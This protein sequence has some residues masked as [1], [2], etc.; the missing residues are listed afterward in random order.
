MEQE[1]LPVVSNDHLPTFPSE[2]SKWGYFIEKEQARITIMKMYLQSAQM[3]KE[4][5]LDILS[6]TQDYADALLDYELKIA[7]S[8]KA[9]P[10]QQG[11]RTD[12]KP[13]SLAATKSETIA[14]MGLSK[15]QAR[16][17]EGLDADSVKQAKQEARAK[18]LIVTR[19][20]ALNLKKK[21]HYKENNKKIK[22]EGCFNLKATA[23]SCSIEPLYYTQLFANVGIGEF[24]LENLN[25]KV[26]VANELVQ[27]RVQWYKEHHP[28]AEVVCG[29]ITNETVFNSLVALHKEKG[30]KL[31][32]A[33]P[34]CQDFSLAGKR[35]FKTPRAK[36][37]LTMLDFIRDVNDVN[38]YVM[39]ENVPEFLDAKPEG[40]NNILKGETIGEYIKSTLSTLGYQ[41]NIDVLDAADYDTAQ[42]R[43][44]GIILASKIGVWAFPKKSDT[45]I[46]LWEAIGDLPSLEAGE[47]S[48]IPYH[49]A[50]KLS[51]N[52]VNVL[53]HTPTGCSA[54]D[55]PESYK[56]VKQDGTKSNASFKS[57]F[58]RKDWSKPCNTITMKSDNPSGHRTIH[59]GRPKTDGTWSDARCFTI[60]ELLRVTGLPDNYPIPKWATDTLVRD[61][62]GECF[63][64]KLVKKLL[65]ELINLIEKSKIRE[66]IPFFIEIRN[67]IIRFLIKAPKNYVLNNM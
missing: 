10:T 9:I 35:D 8:I 48:N 26:A 20:M 19:T 37:F 65:L 17:I 62:I 28:N 39:I 66:I 60:L 61:A 18:G 23:E 24:Y 54:H 47:T 40:L 63:C 42:H 22:W 44:R 64:P 49:N 45:Q 57:S 5:Y 21:K 15:K 59:P 43:K 36:L 50:P 30:C 55:N 11:Q 34:P 53:R 41:V 25:V 33:S 67:L 46:M 2:M 16:L 12:L 38:E 6:W 29:D 58:Q 52:I 3:S 56:P 13:S 1:L 27:S 31:I 7:D 14:S 51:V 32:L 4:K